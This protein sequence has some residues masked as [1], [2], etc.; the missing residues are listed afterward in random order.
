[1]LILKI[2][3]RAG[4]MCDLAFSVQKLTARVALAFLLLS[5]LLR[6]SLGDFSADTY[7]AYRL[8]EELSRLPAGIL[9]TGVIAAVCIEDIR[10]DPP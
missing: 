1:M 5:L 3:E 8:A 9:L 10:G 2:L 6:L 7:A 4:R